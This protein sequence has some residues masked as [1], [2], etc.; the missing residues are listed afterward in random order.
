[1]FDDVPLD[2]LTRYI[3]WM[4]FFNAWEFAGKFP[5]ILNDPVV[6]EAASNLYAD[7][8]AM[9][10]ADRSR[11]RWLTARGVIGFFPANSVETTTSR[12][13][14]TNRARECCTACTSCASRRTSRTGQ[15]H[16]CA[17]RFH[18]AEGLAAVATTSARSR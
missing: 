18:R 6:G 4:P 15:P 5:D 12:C 8:Q 1:M 9:L 16:F 3:D 17:R 11:E 10:Q 13:T 2:D 7:A 14:P